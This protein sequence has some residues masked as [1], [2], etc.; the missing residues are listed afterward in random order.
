MTAKGRSCA[1]WHQPASS[2]PCPIKKTRCS[3]GLVALIR[4]LHR[5]VPCAPAEEDPQEDL[6]LPPWWRENWQAEP[7]VSRA[8]NGEADPHCDNRIAHR[9]RGVSPGLHPAL[10]CARKRDPRLSFASGT[11]YQSWLWQDPG[12]QFRGQ[13]KASRTAEAAQRHQ[14]VG[15][16]GTRAVEQSFL[17]LY[18]PAQRNESQRRGALS[19]PG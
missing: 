14:A 12:S 6:A 9:C 18:T 11:G 3:R 8:N 7:G 16:G 19:R 4:D 1:K 2:C 10:A 15:S 5:Q 17:A 13:Q